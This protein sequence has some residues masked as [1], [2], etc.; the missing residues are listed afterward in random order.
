MFKPRILLTVLLFAL[1]GCGEFTSN[2]RTERQ[3][4]LSENTSTIRQSSS[5]PTVKAFPG[6]LGF[7][8]NTTGGR[9]GRVIKVTNTNDSGNGSLRAAIEA[10]GPRIV[11]FD[12]GGIISLRSPLVIQ[13]RDI[14]IAGQTAPG[15][16]IVLGGSRMIIGTS[17]V[18][19]RGM[20]FRPGSENYG[21]DKMDNRDGLS[22][23]VGD[24]YMENIIVDSNSMTWSVDESLSIWGNVHYLTYSNNLVAEAL[25]N[26]NHPKGAHS[27]AFVVGDKYGRSGGSHLTAVRNILSNSK[28]RCPMVKNVKSF[29]F[30]NNYCFNFNNFFNSGDF[31]QVHLIKNFFQH[32]DASRNDRKPLYLSGTDSHFYL[33]GNRD[34]KYRT[35]DSQSESAL[36]SG[37]LSKVSKTPLFAGSGLPEIPATEIKS[38]LL[39]NAGARWPQLDNTDTRILNDFS[40]NYSRII[41]H[42]SQVGGY[43]S[44][45]AGEAPMDRDNDGMPDAFEIAM[46]Y[47]PDSDDSALDTNGDGYTNIEDYINGIITGFPATPQNNDG[48]SNDTDDSE[49]DSSNSSEIISIEAEDM[50]LESGFINKSASVASGG[51]W[52]QAKGDA[53]AAYTYNGPS[54]IF[55]ITIEYFDENDGVSNMSLQVNGQA[56]SQWLWDKD[57]GSP[58]ANKNTKTSIVFENIHLSSGD[59]IRLSGTSDGSEP[60]RTD[61]II[62]QKA[63]E[64]NVPKLPFL[65]EA[66]DLEILSGFEVKNLGVASEDKILQ[67]KT[68]GKARFIFDDHP[69]TYRLSIGYFDENDGVST[70]SLTLNGS[71]L[72]HWKWNQNFGSSIATRD[73]LTEKTLPSVQLKPGDILTI[74]G[75]AN[76]GEPL[77]TDYIRF[78]FRY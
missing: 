47:N 4:N 35:S 51:Y 33:H 24:A 43:E 50:V 31:A 76:G 68:T 11:V 62:L 9:G 52:I 42:P 78:E 12:T 72:S 58:L 13:N 27:M 18:I 22:T 34:D 61:R 16:G 7:G 39:K 40:T 26:A 56:L 28:F 71:T 65:V 15:K 69:G 53:S 77:R 14:T 48:E 66:E 67:T 5:A 37:S 41:D 70:M 6:A 2:S 63:S 45:P 75:V 59:V 23:G 38:Y 8:A 73:V 20:R 57:L 3:H 64:T 55:K 54:A 46:G 36:A 10:S 30:I 21:D 60:L 17:N 19:V 44:Y 32:G 25:N 49:D 74:E 29:E 1:T